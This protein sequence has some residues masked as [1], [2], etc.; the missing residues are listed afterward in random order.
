M[1]TMLTAKFIASL[2]PA[3]PGTR[4]HYWDALVPGLGV[5]VTARGTKSF[6]VYRRW[7]GSRA[8]ARRSLGNAAKLPLATAR[9]RARDWLALVE[10]GV[11]PK[12]QAR[13]VAQAAQRRRQTTFAA[14]AEAWFAD[15]VKTQRLGA[16]VTGEVR[17]EFITRWGELP[18]TELTTLDIREVIKAKAASAPA[19]ARNLLGHLQRMFTW[20][21]A[22][23][24]YGLTANPA[25][26][27]RPSK[28]IGRKVMRQR[29]LT[30]D[31]L[32]A[33]WAASAELDYPYGPLLQMLMLTGQRRSEV[34]EARWPEFHLGKRLWTIPPERMK[35]AAAHVVPLTDP[36][37]MTL[38]SL[39]RFTKGDHVFSASFGASPVTGFSRLKDRLAKLLGGG[40]DYVLHDVR[41]T[42]RTHLSAL[43]ITE[44]VRELVIA[45]AQPG[46]HKVYDRHGYEA[47]KRHAL[48]LWAARLH[49]IVAPAKG[50]NVVVLR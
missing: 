4:A 34:A 24:A 20:A 50:S 32:R 3:A 13:Q 37:L 46:L 48:E 36:V 33:L 7:P 29:V 8:P 10:R 9:E 39:P 12:D 21:V 42:M 6:V 41:R 14:V 49:T 17:R 38:Q 18:I 47:E 11:D 26:P 28:L 22:Q 5:R 15:E 2:K 27:L 35:G 43:P 31:E 25:A 16:K 45:H 44:R 1:R 30:D 40:T 19:Q 23:H